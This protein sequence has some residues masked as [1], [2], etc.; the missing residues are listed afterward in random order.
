M[1]QV[2][3]EKVT[4]QCPRCYAE[5]VLS[6]PLSGL[7]KWEKGALIQDALPGLSADDREALMTGICPP[8]WSVMFPPETGE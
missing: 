2:Q 5:R 1:G 4:T 6:V 8:C 3:I 7:R